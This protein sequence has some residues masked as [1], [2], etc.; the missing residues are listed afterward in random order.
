[1]AYTIKLGTFAKKENS[2]AQP[3]TTGW[4][5]YEINFKQGSNFMAPSFTLSLDFETAQTYNYAELFNKYYWVKSLDVARTGFVEFKL[6]IDVLATYRTE[7]G[8]TPLYILRAANEYDGDIID[9]LYPRTIEKITSGSAIA[10]E[11]KTLQSGN[12]IV[13]V[14]GSNVGSSSLYQLTPAQ[15]STFI[16]NLTA[17]VKYTRDQ[18][19]GQDIPQAI[20]NSMFN[21]TDYIKS[22]MWVPHSFGGGTPIR[23]FCG[24]WDSGTDGLIVSGGVQEVYNALLAVPKH[25]LAATRGAYMNSAPFSEYYID[26]QPFGIIALDSVLLAKTE[27]IL[28]KLYVDCITGAGLLK[29]SSP[30]LGVLCSN[31]A[32]YGVPISLGEAQSNINAIASGIGGLGTIA[33]GMATMNPAI[34]A[35][36]AAAVLS[37]TESS[38]PRATTSG[39][40]GSLCAHYTDKSLIATFYSPTDDDV[41]NNGRPLCAVRTPSSIGGFMIAQKSPINIAAELEEINKIEAYLTS[42]FY[43]E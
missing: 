31:V 15:F 13:N 26:F 37:S 43:Y 3:D 40:Q 5:S 34:I 20:Y 21:P 16:S 19:G 36:G 9:N 30:E 22:I 39:S 1:M 41:A 11:G 6:E 7:I 28:L 33:A 38:I 17:S 8:T 42:G 35:G 32:Q 27:S 18:A 10:D 24:L 25:P 14:L 2:T 12:Y 29:L 4:A 23:I